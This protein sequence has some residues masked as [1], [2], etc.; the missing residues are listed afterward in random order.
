MKIFATDKA[1]PGTNTFKVV[2]AGV[3]NDRTFK[4]KTD[5]V[6]LVVSPAESVE[7]A[8]PPAAAAAAVAPATSTTK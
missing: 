7:P 5:Q 8:K 3:L 4:R 1:V 6:T 2:G